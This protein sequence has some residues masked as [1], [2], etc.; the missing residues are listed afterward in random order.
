MTLNEFLAK[1]GQILG[2]AEK[3]ASVDL[4]AANQKIATLEASLAESEK[5]N[6]ALAK[7]VISFTEQLETLNA[8]VGTLTRERDEAKATIADP[9]GAIQTA[10]AT[11][12]VEITSA[13]GQPVPVTVAASAAA[14]GEDLLTQYYACPTPEAK[15]AFYRKHSAALKAAWSTK[16][17]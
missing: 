8:K 2:L 10:A 17:K 6:S 5:S 4:D 3:G 7:D 9:K 16:R 1:A 15:T 12:A 14:G 11:K 13:Q